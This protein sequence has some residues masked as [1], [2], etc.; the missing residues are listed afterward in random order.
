MKITNWGNYPVV[1]AAVHSPESVDELKKIVSSHPEMIARGLGRC[2]GDSSLNYTIVSTLR[3][4]HLL[5]FDEQTGIIICES[6]VSFSELLE[7]FVPRGWFLPVT[8][9]TKFVTVGGAIASDVHGKN[10][11]IAG[12][13]SNHLEWVKILLGD[14]SIVQCSKDENSD[15]FWSTCGGM[16]LTGI[17]VEASF[18]MLK[19][20]TAYIRQRVIKTKNL[21]ETIE[22]FEANKYWTYSVAWIDCLAKGNSLGRSALILGEHA[23]KNEVGYRY[24][25]PLKIEKRMSIPFPFFL[26][27]FVLN[28]QT[29]KIFNEIRYSAYVSKDSFVEYEPF[30]YPLDV[31]SHWNRMYGKRGFTQ[32]Q[33]VLPKESSKEG[34]KKLLTKITESGEGSFLAVLKLFGKQEGLLSFPREGFTLALDFVISPTT[35]K[36]FNELDILVN[37]YGGRLYLSKDVRMTK[38]VFEKGYS[39][40]NKFSNL[41]KKYDVQQKFQSLQSK[42]IGI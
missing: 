36:L 6:G 18:K 32:Y 2:Y 10:H 42:R 19:I 1:D 41:K 21:D 22:A 34:L 30:F 37:E 31:I 20:E 23:T 35:L 5:A 40:F 28:S 9:G 16:G 4:N 3:F 15:L 29:V 27:N 26:P 33:F 14:G 17:I 39:N 38:D 25:N 12:S 24:R 7:I 8:P 11:H 13:F